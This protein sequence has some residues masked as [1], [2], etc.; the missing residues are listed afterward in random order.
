M[1]L[2]MTVY[3]VICRPGKIFAG[4]FLCINFILPSLLHSQNGFIQSYCYQD[5]YSVVFNDIILEGDTLVIYG[6]ARNPL[7]GQI[8]LYFT[9]MDTFGNILLEVTH[10]DAQGDDYFFELDTDL[11]ACSD[12]GY[13]LTGKAF[14]RNSPVLIKLKHDGT[15]DFVNEYPDNSVFT[16]KNLSVVENETG[17]ITV[18]TKQQMSD[19]MNDVFIIRTDKSGNEIWE[20]S[21]GEPNVWET[22]RDIHK[23]SENEFMISGAIG[24][25]SSQVQDLTDQ[26]SINKVFKFD[27]TGQIIWEWEGEMRFNPASFGMYKLQFAEDGNLFSIG[28]TTMIVED[29]ELPFLQNEVTK[30]DENFEPIVSTPILDH[31]SSRNNLSDL[32]PGLDNEWIAVGRYVHEVEEPHNY[33]Y[34]ASLIAKVNAAGDLLWSRTD[35]LIADFTNSVDHYLGGVVVLPSGSIIAC[36]Q[37][38]N[39]QPQVDKSYGWLIKVDKD[40]CIDP[41]CNPSSSSKR[42]LDGAAYEVFPNP[43]HHELNV[44]GEGSFGLDLIDAKGRLLQSI[45]DNHNTARMNLS[46]YPAGNYYLRI[47]QGNSWALRKVIKQ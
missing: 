19:G 20:I 18:G 11:L 14:F 36:G 5:E 24:V 9:K 34:D 8:G 21:Y 2:N 7:N 22:F 35:T 40:G 30:R 37:V 38:N 3:N 31:S 17:Y 47:K 1:L 45:E 46:A 43:A 29:Y 28:V 42:L 26:W 6:R 23:I 13:A 16:I 33:F 32:T 4:I 41:K 39:L 27:T 15:L 44:S 12:G 25:L 10:Y